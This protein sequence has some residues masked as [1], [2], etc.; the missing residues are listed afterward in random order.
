[1]WFGSLKVLFVIV[2][3]GLWCPS[4][5]LC[6]LPVQEIAA[7]DPPTLA[8]ANLTLMKKP[9]TGKKSLHVACQWLIHLLH[10]EINKNKM[11][12]DFC[13]LLSCWKNKM[14]PKQCNVLLNCSAL[15][16]KWSRPASGRCAWPPQMSVTV[17]H[18]YLCPS[19][20]SSLSAP[21]QQPLSW[22]LGKPVP[23]NMFVHIGCRFGACLCF[24]IGILKKSKQKLSKLRHPL[25]I[26]FMMKDD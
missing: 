12:R 20:K 21:E 5:V 15:S 8:A 2:S 14:K 19:N 10:P 6:L 23:I 17:I 11:N 3:Q 24:K 16:A 25:L 26:A 4:L 9:Q 1:M 13:K 7:G 18:K 22:Q